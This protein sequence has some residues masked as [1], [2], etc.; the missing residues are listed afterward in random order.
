MA[1][2]EYEADR[3]AL[4][5]TAKRL[6]VSVFIDSRARYRGQPYVTLIHRRMTLSVHRTFR[7]AA[8][9]LQPPVQETSE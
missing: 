3:E 5:E 8:A 1:P 9:W 4:L 2:S 6:R 7:D